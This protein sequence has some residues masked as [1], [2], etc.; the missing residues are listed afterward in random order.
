MTR[1][2]ADPALEA[3][4]AWLIQAQDAPDDLALRSR[5]QAWIDQDRDHRRAWDQA[6]QAW[7]LLGES[8]AP[9]RLAHLPR[10]R[11]WKRVTAL[12]LAACLAVAILPGL[13]ARLVSDHRTGT[14]EMRLV[15]LDDGSQVHLAPQSALR[16]RH[17]PDQRG[18]DLLAGE[19]F[20]QIR[21]D[22]ARPFVVRAQG[23]ETRVLGTAF[24]V[25]LN[26]DSV[27][28]A[29]QSGLVAVTRDGAPATH[30]GAGDAL[31]VDRAD[32][33]ARLQQVATTEVAGW[34]DGALFFVDTPIAEVVDN[35]R[36][37]HSG[38]IVLPDSDLG[39]QRVTGLYDPRDMPRALSA[40]VRPAGGQVRT[41]S[42]WIIIV[43]GS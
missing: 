32:G 6:R 34:R 9:E 26:H 30:L 15:V 13:G 37:Y 17:D 1:P 41:V 19:A 42:P 18:V 2:P 22:P 33:T 23:V 4:V 28:V 29:V 14:G 25:R 43:S 8:P 10:P 20:F 35:L 21:P 12:A 24:D 36:R 16:L 31:D 27:R 11:P 40:L 3:A 7:A 39:R 38:W 5:I